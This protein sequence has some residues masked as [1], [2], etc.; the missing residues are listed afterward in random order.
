MKR[1]IFHVMHYRFKEHF[2]FKDFDSPVDGLTQSIRD[3]NEEFPPCLCHNDMHVL[4]LIYA[5]DQGRL[6]S[7]SPSHFVLVLLLV[8]RIPLTLLHLLVRFLFVYLL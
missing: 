3:I 4:N 2:D 7:L 8:T 5:E 6:V 1:Y